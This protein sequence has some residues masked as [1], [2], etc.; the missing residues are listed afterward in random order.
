M[1]LADNKATLK[2]DISTDLQSEIE[3]AY[4]LVGNPDYDN[5][6]L[7]KFTD[8]MADVLVEKYMDYIPANAELNNANLNDSNV[9]QTS[10]APDEWDVTDTSVS[11]GVI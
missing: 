1:A 5:A 9:D 8:L 2:S 11:G 10:V 7:K 4:G 3:S 6:E